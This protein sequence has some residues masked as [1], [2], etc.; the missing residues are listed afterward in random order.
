MLLAREETRPAWLVVQTK[1]LQERV[2]EIWLTERGLDVYCPRILKPPD[3]LRA[4]RSPVP[5]FRQ[6]LFCR[7]APSLGID[8]IRYSPGVRR[9]VRF[10]DCLAGLDDSE[11][12]YLRA[13]EEGRGFLVIPK[14]SITPGERVLLCSGPFDGFEA[15]LDGYVASKD[16]VRVLLAVASGTWRITGPSKAVEASARREPTPGSPCLKGASPG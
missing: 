5:L 1:A 7:A 13:R 16:R 14:P 8:V 15:V 3:H 9:V 12:A 10:G 2:A 11:V 4:P 6:Y